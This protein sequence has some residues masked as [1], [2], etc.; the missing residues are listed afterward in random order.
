MR[1]ESQN[2]RNR[3]LTLTRKRLKDH[4]AGYLPA[5]QREG[6]CKQA[7]VDPLEAV[8]Y[9]SDLLDKLLQ[10]P[11][12]PH[13]RMVLWQPEYVEDVTA[14]PAQMVAIPDTRHIISAMALNTRAKVLY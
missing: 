10:K 8:K 3:C 11:T 14:Q 1:H 7:Y 9:E 2:Q 5:C 4:I 12:F 6:R 13:V